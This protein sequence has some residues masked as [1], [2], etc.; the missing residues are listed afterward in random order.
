M[1]HSQLLLAVLIG[2]W[3]AA[4]AVC[5]YAQEGGS[6]IITGVTISP[7]G[8]KVVIKYHGQIGKHAAFVMAQPFRLVVDFHSADLGQVSRKISVNR[9]PIREIRLGQDQ[10]R[11]RVVVDFGSNPVPPFQVGRM[12]NALSVVFGDPE[13]RRAVGPG[14]EGITRAPP[15]NQASVPSPARTSAQSHGSAMVVKKAGVQGSLVVVDLESS[16]DPGQQYRLTMDVDLDRLVL[17]NATAGNSEGALRRFDVVEKPSPP[18]TRTPH[19]QLQDA[20][21]PHRGDD[22]DCGAKPSVRKF[23]WGLPTVKTREPAETGGQR[24]GPFKL[25]KFELQARKGDGEN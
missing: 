2:I 19:D 10:S 8:K 3:L 21:R 1:S 18:V 23:K 4:S 6:G 25:E 9:D 14:L 17:K 13:T 20:Q 5:G 22:P 12:D 24:I 7:D 16:K 15:R 11:A